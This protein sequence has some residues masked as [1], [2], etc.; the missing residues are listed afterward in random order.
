MTLTLS[1]DGGRVQNESMVRVHLRFLSLA[2]ARQCLGRLA[3]A[4]AVVSPMLLVVLDH[5][6]AERIPGHEHVAP[7]GQPVAT[8]AHLFE[9]RHGH[10]LRETDLSPSIPAVVPAHPTA[11]AALT[12]VEHLGLPL[13]LLLITVV[14]TGRSPLPGISRLTDQIALGPPTPPPPVWLGAH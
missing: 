14:L 11:L 7:P 3:L 1:R 9:Q 10:A 6:G 5:H 4:L 13:L 2:R 12:L 8:H